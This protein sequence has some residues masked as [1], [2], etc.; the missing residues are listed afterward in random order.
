MVIKSSSYY[1]VKIIEG[2]MKRINSY[3]VTLS[4]SKA[5]KSTHV[6][7]Y[8]DRNERVKLEA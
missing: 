1:S 7:Q 3:R 2:I 4:F 5:K 8:E 6:L